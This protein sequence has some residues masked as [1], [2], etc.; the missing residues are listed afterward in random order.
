MG[1]QAGPAPDQ[2]DDVVSAHVLVAGPPVQPPLPAGIH[3][4]Q[5]AQKQDDDTGGRREGAP[6]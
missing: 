5:E 2:A 3:H 4:E 1:A 6:E